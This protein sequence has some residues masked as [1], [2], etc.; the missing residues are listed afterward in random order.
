[1]NYTPSK[2]EIKENV[3]AKLSRYFGCTPKEASRDQMYKAVSMTVKATV[4]SSSLW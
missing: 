2:K 4:C 1:M 3:E